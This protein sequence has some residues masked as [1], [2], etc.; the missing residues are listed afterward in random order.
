MN[1]KSNIPS[2]ALIAALIAVMGV[3]EMDLGSFNWIKRKGKLGGKGFLEKPEHEQHRLLSDS[4]D[5]YGYR[6]TLGSIMALERNR[7]IKR[8]HGRELAGLRHWLVNTYGGEGSFGSGNQ[9]VNKN[10]VE[11]QLKKYFA[12]PENRQIPK[13][14]VKHE[15]ERLEVLPQNLRTT[16]QKNTLKMLKEYS[17]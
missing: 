8:R 2:K 11:S 17:S 15:I 13:S 3:S 4:V 1:W 9:N 5:E 12:I 10:S 16:R 6:S 7:E 14:Y